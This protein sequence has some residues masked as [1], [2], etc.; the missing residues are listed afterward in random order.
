M[1]RHVPSTQGLAPS[2][3]LIVCFS[4]NVD[5]IHGAVGDEA[6]DDLVEGGELI[7][8]RPGNAVVAIF[9]PVMRH[10]VDKSVRLGWSRR[11]RHH[12]HTL[13]VR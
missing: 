8:D 5:F 11:G 13:S 7:Y 3:R 6:L 9:V 10:V 12:P 1:T 2:F 4:P